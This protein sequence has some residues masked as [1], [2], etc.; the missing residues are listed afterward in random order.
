MT[1]VSNIL[2]IYFVSYI[3]WFINTVIGDEY[4]ATV[5]LAPYQRIPKKKIDKD[6]NW[7]KIHE[8]PVFLEFKRNFEQKTIDTTLKTTQH[9]FE[10]VEG[11][12][13]LKILFSMY[14]DL[15]LILLP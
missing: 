11:K 4:P 10:S 8:N 9:F 14:F 6:P 3:K 7:G 2:Y 13:T 1:L 15:I 12:S 5:E